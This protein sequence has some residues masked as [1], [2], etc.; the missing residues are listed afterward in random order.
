[1]LYLPP[2]V[3]HH[4]VAEDA[5][6]TFSIGMRAPRRPELLGDFVDT[7]IADADEALRY[8]I[9]TLP[10]AIRTRSMRRRW[11]RVI[12]ALNAL[13]MNDPE[14]LGDW[15]G[16][17]SRCTAA[18]AK[19]PRPTPLAHRSRV[20]PGTRRPPASPSVDSRMAWRKSGQ[21]ARL[22][23]S[24]QE[25]TAAG[26]RCAHAGG[27]RRD[28]WPA[29]TPAVAAPAAMPCSLLAGRPLPLAVEDEEE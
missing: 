23:A 15:F 7:L 21:G 4:G 5:C 26:A 22:Y 13:R 19:A 14:R 18:P 28:R 11:Q 27:G 3:P 6:L 2:G 10:P 9:R 24:G 12:A 16:R 17:S 1:M 20:G 8:A 25:F 29:C